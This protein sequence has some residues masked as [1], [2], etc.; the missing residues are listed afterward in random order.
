MKE[1]PVRYFSEYVFF[2]RFETKKY[3]LPVY[4]NAIGDND[5]I[6]NHFKLYDGLN[7]HYEMQFDNGPIPVVVG[8]NGNR[9]KSAFSVKL[10]KIARLRVTSWKFENE[11][12]DNG[13]SFEGRLANALNQAE[14]PLP[15]YDTV[16]ARTVFRTNLPVHII[17][18]DI[19]D[20]QELLAINIID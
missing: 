3:Y 20:Y 1:S 4:I 11:E 2:N 15:F 7:E 10:G 6:S 5:A 8:L 13:L 17:E 14:L 9:I 18:G 16:I 12:E 19:G